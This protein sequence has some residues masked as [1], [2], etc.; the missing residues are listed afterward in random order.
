V[1]CVCPGQK[2]KAPMYSEVKHLLSTKCPVPSQIV[3]ANTIAKGKGLRSIVNKV[4]MQMCA[5]IGG[6]PWAID[7]VPYSKQPTMVCGL[8]VYGKT[9][10]GVKKTIL[11][12]TASFNR[13][14]TRYISIAKI[15][16][17]GEE[18]ASKIKDCIFEAIK[19]FS[20]ANKTPPKHIIL[21]RDG[22]SSSQIAQVINT[23]IP[24]IKAAFKDS[25]LSIKLT[26]LVVNK[27]NKSKFFMVGKGNNEY[28]NPLPGTL[29]NDT[30][31]VPE[32]KEFYLISQKTPQGTASPIHYQSIYD[33]S[34]IDPS[35]MYTFVYKLCYL[36]FNW[37][38][39]IKVP[40]PVHYAKKL[41][42]MVGDHLASFNTNGIPNERLMTG[43]KSLFY[44]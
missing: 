21:I 29:I 7:N 34:E 28:Q 16:N 18:L 42:F 26:M 24:Q 30:V 23:D 4:L 41:A 31:T 10:K 13:T 8:D 2:M 44:I 33:D 19:A 38:G 17:E 15:Q 22:I 12:F 14:F 9:I 3:L 37:S 20:E 27:K 40:A 25:N 43:L 39:S 5:K 6:E 11:A 35:E 32:N 36:Y 1:L